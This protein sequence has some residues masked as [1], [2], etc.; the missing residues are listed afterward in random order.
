MAEKITLTIDPE[1]QSLIPPLT[2]T[3]RAQLDAN[4]L[5]EGCREAMV[6]WAG[7]SPIGPAHPCP[8]PWVRQLPL[9]STRKEMTW[10]C[11]TCDE[12]WQR[13]YVLLD[14]HHR[15]TI[16]Q[17]RNIPFD[18]VDAPA[19]V[20]NR[21]D[22]KLWIIRNQLGRRNLPRGA[23]VE[24][25]LQM[26]SIVAVQARERQRQAGR[27]KLPQNSTEPIET[28]AELAEAADVSTD[29]I[30]KGEVV[31]READEPMKAAV[32]TGERSIHSVYQALR[33]P[34]PRPSPSVHSDGS[35]A[36][37]PL[38]PL[39][40]R[41]GPDVSADP[42][43]PAAPV[44]MRPPGHETAELSV[45]S[46]PRSDGL[47]ARQEDLGTPAHRCLTLMGALYAELQTME[48]L[49]DMIHI[50][51]VSSPQASVDALQQCTYLISTLQV[52]EQALH[53]TVADAQPLLGGVERCREANPTPDDSST[54]DAPTGDRR[55]GA[56]LEFEGARV[57][58]T[59]TL[60][61]RRKPE[62]D[63]GRSP[64]MDAEP[65]EPSDVSHA[66][67]YSVDPILTVGV[68][69]AAE[70]TCDERARQ[71]LVERIVATFPGGVPPRRD[72]VSTFVKHLNDEAFPPPHGART[73][74][75]AAMW[76]QLRALGYPTSSPLR[77]RS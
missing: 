63:D 34:K 24:L 54:H 28:R 22:A 76:Q 45:E 68:Q 23:R 70:A 57:T 31:F 33:P 59:M 77:K 75:M 64:S 1:F 16:C 47:S 65:T 35:T 38:V 52:I 17:A 74:H 40:A 29:T 26:K 7:E 20:E 3:E 9:E 62:G 66:A 18:T 13:P 12:M 19:W 25:A 8:E 60:E 51:Q 71:A 56:L 10:I 42:Q 6:V 53:T 36:L 61:A 49:H 32:R 73:W 50:C 37:P 5:E 44:P 15:Y 72:E 55:T 30:R 69:A 27:E 46:P 58:A 14:G 11:P 4:L 41:V 67:V 48:D 39:T 21:E 2:D 43:A